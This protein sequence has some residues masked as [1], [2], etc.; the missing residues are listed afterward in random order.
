MIP[1]LVKL[2]AIIFIIILTFIVGLVYR[3]WISVGHKTK[4][5]PSVFGLDFIYHRLSNGQE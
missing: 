2:F 4:A 1:Q 5:M 3:V